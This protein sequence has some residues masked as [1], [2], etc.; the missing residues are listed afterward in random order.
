M[1][2]N[3][4]SGCLNYV[5]PKSTKNNVRT[6]LEQSLP[7]LDCWKVTSAVLVFNIEEWSIAKNYHPNLLK[8]LVNKRPLSITPPTM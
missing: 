1:S 5:S 4:Y 3:L 8:K 2:K 7:I 6:A